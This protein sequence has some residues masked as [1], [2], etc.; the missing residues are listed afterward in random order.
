MADEKYSKYTFIIRNLTAENHCKQIKLSELNKDKALLVCFGGNGTVTDRT[1]NNPL[2]IVEGMMGIKAEDVNSSS[3]SYKHLNVISCVYGKDNKDDSV[4]RLSP[5][6]YA[7]IATDLLISRC[8]DENGSLLPF[9]DCCKN[10]SLL[11]FFSHCEGAVSVNNIFKSFSRQIKQLGMTQ[12][13]LQTL[14][15]IPMQITYAPYC[16]DTP[17]PTIRFNSMTDSLNRDLAQTYKSIYGHELNGI[18]TQLDEAGT[19]RGMKYPYVK[20]E[21][22]SIYC[23]RLL[24]VK[25]NTDYS[26]LI[27]E[28]TIVGLMRDDKWQ[29]NTASIWDAG[30]RDPLKNTPVAADISS[31][32]LGYALTVAAS[33]SI[34]NA[35]SDEFIPKPPMTE[36]KQSLDSI[37][38]SVSEDALKVPTQEETQAQ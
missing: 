17:I 37:I 35:W 19:F 7:E 8:V 6:E 34:Q 31:K 3:S 13:Q 16:N 24:N 4:G 2:S 30:G 1:A 10:F 12:E 32:V 15:A 26:N 5:E 38:Y 14:T 28:H 29:L 21:L 25:E 33:N 36:I 22:L 9:E 23:S 18:E 27:D 11:N 20:H